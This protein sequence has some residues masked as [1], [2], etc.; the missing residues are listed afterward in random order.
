M[1]GIAYKVIW[2]LSLLFL[3][4]LQWI[5]FA[6]HICIWGW[7]T[8]LFSRTLPGN[9]STEKPAT[10]CGSGI[11]FYLEETLLHVVS[12]RE[13]LFRMVLRFDF[14]LSLSGNAMCLF[15]QQFQWITKPITP[16]E[17]QLFVQQ[18]RL[19]DWRMWRGM[20]FQRLY[21]RFMCEYLHLQ[22]FF[23]I[24]HKQRNWLSILH[25]SI[26][27]RDINFFSM[28]MNTISSLRYIWV[29]VL[30]SHSLSM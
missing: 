18:Q 8:E 28:R 27:S 23:L 13:I 22:M 19:V 4:L 15:I 29:I 5:T 24:W 10:F 2:P 9:M 20:D 1:L 17:M 12:Y 14:F 16:T 11:F 21:D 3:R 26:W 25:E 7:I 6:T 30:L